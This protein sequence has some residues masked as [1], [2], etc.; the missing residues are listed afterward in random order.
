[1]EVIM[2]ELHQ[3]DCKRPQKGEGLSN[4]AIQ[5]L[6]GQVQEWELVDEDGILQLEREFEFKNFAQAL[7]FTNQVGELAEQQDHHPAIL[8]EWG[9]VTVTFWTHA[10]GGLHENDFIMA[11]KTDRL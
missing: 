4:E 7:A 2:S 6:M 8:T 3:L 10:T 1:M 11:A 9:R 5:E